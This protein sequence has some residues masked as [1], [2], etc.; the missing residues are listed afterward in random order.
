MCRTTRASA[1]GRGLL[2]ESPADRALRVFMVKA[3][4]N[5]LN[6]PG[7]V[8]RS[9]ELDAAH[10]E[11]VGIV[12]GLLKEQPW[13]VECRSLLAST[14]L[15]QGTYCIRTGQ[16]GQAEAVNEEA[17]TIQRRLAED[18]PDR[19]EIVHELGV[20]S[21]GIAYMKLFE[22]DYK[23]V[24]EWTGRAARVFEES[25]RAQ[26][27]RTDIKRLLS[28]AYHVQAQ[29]LTDQRRSPEALAEWE[30]A[31]AFAQ[32]GSDRF[33][34]LVIS[35]ALV[36]AYLGDFGRAMDEASAASKTGS[37]AGVNLYN[38]ACIFALAAAAAAKDVARDPAGRTALAEKYAEHA[39]NSL[40]E[41]RR[42]GYFLD[43]LNVDLIRSD[44]DVHLLRT[45][46]DFQDFVLDLTFPDDPL[47]RP[48]GIVDSV[49]SPKE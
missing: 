48:R 46:A 8:R 4:M 27:G 36:R 43:P 10:V 19:A 30:R 28:M 14:L 33:H 40:A 1:L 20:V 45:R 42:A 44:P 35:R 24:E 21:Y 22:K 7:Y 47:A 16:P 15:A 11:A 49:V 17:L 2:E 41:S 5:L 34:T 23:A 6:L 12:R 3:T 25:L 29:A 31:I 38:E 39:M 32:P 26:P 9:A 13:S 37:D 18:H